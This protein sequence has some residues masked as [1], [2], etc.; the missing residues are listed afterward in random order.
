LPEEAPQPTLATRVLGGTGQAV[1]GWGEGA[2]NAV[3][4]YGAMLVG[5]WNL[6]RHPHRIRWTAIVRQAQLV[7]IDR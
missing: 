5:M 7:G 3:E 4:F 6:L 1:L 2:L